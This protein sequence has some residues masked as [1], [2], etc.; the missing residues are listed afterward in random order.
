MGK[1]NPSAA[2]MATVVVTAAFTTAPGAA[3]AGVLAPTDGRRINASVWGTFSATVAIERSFDGGTT[4]VPVSRDMIGTGTA[5]TVP[6]SV[7]IVETES[8]VLY[9]MSLSAYTSGTANVRLSY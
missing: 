6:A 9:R 3:T 2:D 1:P 8:G 4:W 5:F 7:Q